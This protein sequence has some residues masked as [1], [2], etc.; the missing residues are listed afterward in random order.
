MRGRSRL[1]NRSTE[2]IPAVWLV[3]RRDVRAK[4]LTLAGA[5]PADVDGR[6][7]THRFA[8]ARPMKP[9]EALDLAFDLVLERRGPKADGEDYDLLP[10]GSYVH[11]LAVLPTVGYRRSFEL[12]DEADRRRAGL[13]ER[14]EEEPAETDFPAAAGRMTFDV[15]VTTPADQLPVAPGVLVSSNVANGRRTSRFRAETPVTAFFAVA[16]ARYA[17]DRVR[18]AGVDVE[19]YSHPRHRRNIAWI[20]EAA[21]RALDYCVARYG[22]YPFAQLR[23]AEVPAAGLGGAG[24]ALP[25]VVYLSEERGFLIDTAARGRIDLL[26]KRVAHEVA[27]QWWGHQLSPAP[28]PGSTAL[29]ESLARHTELRVLAARHGVEAL[30]PVLDRE[31]QR[32]LSGRTA[33]DEVPLVDV[34]HQAYLYYSKG[35]L[36]MAALTELAGE[37]AVDG[38]LRGLFLGTT[39]A[40][41]APTSGDL[42]GHLLRATPAEQRPLV[43]EWWTRIA[44]HDVRVTSATAARQ[45]DG[46]TSVDVVLE[47]SKTDATDGVEKGVPF[48]EA[49]EV[50]VTSADP[51]AG[52][53]E[54]P[55]LHSGRYRVTGRTRLS[56]PV[57]GRPGDVVVDPRHLFLDRNRADNVRSVG[58]VP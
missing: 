22:P 38:A 15:A 48:D 31:L 40:G 14:A 3:V 19:V 43:E 26:T 10:N 4:T 16:S 7:G 52:G 12:V 56:I 49:V 34:R 18:H 46:R 30:R 47:A 17:V 24:F 45:S 35:S 27:H 13:P 11:G 23:L 9:G 21:T 5:A 58:A 37:D 29:V 32:Y 33:G 42:L 53:S 28:G 39:L 20:L 54:G 6:F 51:G 55:P 1:E 44:L 8:L 25:G 36:A 2:E 50:V 57:D 41:R